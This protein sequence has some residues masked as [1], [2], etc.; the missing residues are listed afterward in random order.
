M[1]PNMLCCSESMLP[2][3][4]LLIYLD[5]LHCQHAVEDCAEDVD[6]M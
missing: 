2:D 5:V 4:Q 3:P 6:F 1:G